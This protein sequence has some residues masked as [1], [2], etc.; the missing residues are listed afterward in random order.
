MMERLEWGRLLILAIGLVLGFVVAVGVGWLFS[1]WH[2]PGQY[3]R[4]GRRVR[5]ARRGVLLLNPSS[6]E[7]KV[8]RF[9]L[10]EEARR[11][12]IEAVVLDEG[13]DL[14]ELAEKAVAS[15]A[16]VLGVAGGDGSQAMVADVARAHDVP[17]VC[18][19][20]GLHNHFAI[21]LGL[22]RNDVMAALDG[23]G[24]ALE[25][26]IDLAAVGNRVFVNNAALGLHDTALTA[27]PSEDRRREAQLATAGSPGPELADP[28]GGGELRFDGPDGVRRAAADLV[29]VSN[30]PYLTRRP[31]GGGTRPR[32]D[33]AQLGVVVIRRSRP[34]D[35]EAGT[36]AQPD[37]EEW[38]AATFRTDCT[39]PIQADLDGEAL[40][41]PPPLE[42]RILPGALRVR[43][44]RNA[45]GATR[46]HTRRTL[47][48]R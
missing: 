23:F 31:G 4:G 45:P 35:A 24:D 9:D 41:L 22:D 2:H 21:D 29:L 1:V 44:P 30:N 14:R 12:G 20:A 19:P 15:G 5:P 6:G 13:E 36:A 32:L 8:L 37:V 38:S 18:V 7:G 39:A 3:G 11:R 34:D 42:F 25:L 43:I 46:I 33:S 48:R 26:R 28:T 17:F 47:R 16:D 40:E 27:N 10:V